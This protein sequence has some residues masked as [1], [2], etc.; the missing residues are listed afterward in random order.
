MGEYLASCVVMAVVLALISYISYPGASQKSIKFASSVLLLYT[1]MM[2]V[3]TFVSEIYSVRNISDI[4][5]EEF[6]K[7]DGGEYIEVAEDAFVDGIIKFIVDEYRADRENID[8][9]ISG[10]SFTD[11]RAE[12]ITVYLSGKAALL[13]RRGMESKINGLGLGKCEVFL[14]IG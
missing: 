1:V 6:I 14:D 10:F 11:M 8:V 12:H 9:I 2:P 5:G 3:G 13:D 7:P 4:F